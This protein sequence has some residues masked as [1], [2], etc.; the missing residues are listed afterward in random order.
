[1]E[2]GRCL[3]LSSLHHGADTRTRSLSIVSSLS[4]W[5]A[6]NAVVLQAEKSAEK[7]RGKDMSALIL[8]QGAAVKAVAWASVKL[9]ESKFTH[10]ESS[11]AHLL[12]A[13]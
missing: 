13:Y 2:E 7:K 8:S 12:K 10:T 3:D 4:L 5:A 9:E 11:A 6:A 1:M